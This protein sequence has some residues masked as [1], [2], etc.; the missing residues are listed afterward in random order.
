MSWQVCTGKGTSERENNVNCAIYV[1]QV[2]YCRF[3][4][5]SSFSLMTR[6]SGP[7]T[8]LIGHIIGA[9]KLGT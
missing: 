3:D 2:Y 1:S 6:N 5:A 8:H 7:K 4:R 9:L